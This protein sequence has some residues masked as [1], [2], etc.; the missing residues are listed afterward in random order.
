MSRKHQTSQRQK[1]YKI[2][3]RI[4]NWKQY[5]EALCR[6]GD[7][8]IWLSE[9][10]FRTVDPEEDRQTRSATT[11]FGYCHPGIAVDPVGF[12][13]T[14]ATDNRLFAVHQEDHGSGHSDSS[15]LHPVGSF[16]RP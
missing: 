14:S 9:E 1:S 4:R 2:R 15:L 11:V 8:T 7:V 16:R 5:N 12:H 10:A 13:A 6:R 3:Y